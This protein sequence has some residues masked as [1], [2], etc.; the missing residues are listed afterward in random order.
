MRMRWILASCA[1]MSL[2]A[3]SGAAQVPVDADL[4]PAGYGVLNQ[5]H[6]SVRFTTGDLEVRFLPLDERVLRLVAKDGYESLRGLIDTRRAAIDSAA[7]EAGLTDPGLALVT[8]FALRSDARFDPENL[9]LL[10]RNQLERPLAM[11]P[12]TGNFT[13]RQ[14]NVRTQA[15]AIYLFQIPLPVFELFEL[16]YGGVQ[17]GGWSEALRRL[18][19]ARVQVQARVQAADSAGGKP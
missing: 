15:S 2:G 12:V 16:T 13:G 18:E 3:S 10:Y 7:R 8:F 19:R 17:S 5:D 1:F 4:P 9:N 6:I 14:L 11:I